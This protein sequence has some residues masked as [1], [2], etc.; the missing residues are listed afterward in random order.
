M[1]PAATVKQLALDVGFHACGIA[2][3]TPLTADELGLHRWI[4]EGNHADMRYMERHVA[5]RHDPALLVPG[6][7]TVISL[8]LGYKPSCYMCG[9]NRIAMYAYGDDYHTGI[10]QMLF[11]LIAAIRQVQPGFEAKPCVDTVPVADK[12]WAVRAGLGWLGRNTLLINPTYG[13]LC[14][15]AELVTVT[16]VDSYDL[17]VANRCGDCHRCLDACPNRA[18]QSGPNGGSRLDARRCTSY[19]TVES[20]ASRLPESL[21]RRGYAFGCD[22]CQLVCPYNMQ[23]P[24]SVQI[25]DAQ[26]SELQSLE[27]ADEATFRRLTRHRALNR[28]NYAQWQRNIR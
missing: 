4:A 1:L 9:D 8:L 19:H 10:K 7:Q 28:I 11:R 12:H 17:P 16:L 25:G 2:A 13:S 22:C 14:F 20:R 3:A 6:A 26:L 23:A 18:L 27:H 15:L 21:Q 24:V 5:M